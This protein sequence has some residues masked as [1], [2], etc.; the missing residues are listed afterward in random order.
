[1]VWHEG[2][3]QGACE[4]CDEPYSGYLGVALAWSCWRMACGLN[5]SHDADHRHDK[6]RFKALMHL[7]NRILANRHLR[8]QKFST[9]CV[10]IFRQCQAFAERLALLGHVSAGGTFQ[11][12]M[13]LATAITHTSSSSRD[14]LREAERI[15]VET[16]SSY[17]RTNGAHEE[18]EETIR[19]LL[20]RCRERLAT[21][22]HA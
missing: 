8:R 17:S 22:D 3:L 21:R 20:E 7:G 19:R 2:Y 18:N 10:H 16:R 5:E 13:G 4:N 14:D 6:L 9:E 1:M 12:C 11:V 15:F